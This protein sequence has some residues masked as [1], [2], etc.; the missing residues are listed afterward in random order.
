MRD[1]LWVLNRRLPEDP[2]SSETC[3]RPTR[4]RD[5]N[6]STPLNNDKSQSKIDIPQDGPCNV[7]HSPTTCQLISNCRAGNHRSGTFDGEHLE[8][9]GLESLDMVHFRGRSQTAS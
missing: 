8:R 7:R 4:T 9:E 3:I 6:G 2:G 5:V 1:L